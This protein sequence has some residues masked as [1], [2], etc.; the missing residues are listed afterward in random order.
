MAYLMRYDMTERIIDV[1]KEFSSFVKD[2]ESHF[3]KYSAFMHKA[4]GSE[5]TI[6]N[7]MLMHEMLGKLNTDALVSMYKSCGALADKYDLRSKILTAG[8]EEAD[9]IERT[10]IPPSLRTNGSMSTRIRTPLGDMSWN[11]LMDIGA[12]MRLQES[13]QRGMSNMPPSGSNV[14]PPWSDPKSISGLPVVQMQLDNGASHTPAF[15]PDTLDIPDIPDIADLLNDT[16]LDI[17]VSQEEHEERNKYQQRCAPPNRFIMAA[18][19]RIGLFECTG[20]TGTHNFPAGTPDVKWRRFL[21]GSNH[22]KNYDYRGMKDT[23]FEGMQFIY[24][25]PEKLS[26]LTMSAKE[27]LANLLNTGSVDDIVIDKLN[28]GTYDYYPPSDPVRHNRYDINPWLEWGNKGGE[29]ISDVI[30]PN[31]VLP[32]VL[33][34]VELFLKRQITKISAKIEIESV[35]NFPD[36]PPGFGR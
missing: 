7:T 3:S 8:Y 20:A 27:L 25:Q 16:E 23:R 11:D 21:W 32:E 15:L 30:M 19:C 35:V 1:L 28:I 14:P 18:F 5:A 13:I 34:I 24:R 33:N 10:M 26:L 17:A 36:T 9:L 2:N 4:S 29:N 6:G 12:Q 22:G 31:D